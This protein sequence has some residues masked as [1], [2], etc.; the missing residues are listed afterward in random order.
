MKQMMG[1]KRMEKRVNIANA[2]LGGEPA[3]ASVQRSGE[4]IT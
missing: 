4:I 1:R 2:A 3:A